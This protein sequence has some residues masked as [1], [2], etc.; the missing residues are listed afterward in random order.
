MAQPPLRFIAVEIYHRFPAPGDRIFRDLP[1]AGANSPSLNCPVAINADAAPNDLKSAV[2]G[3]L[4][5][6]PPTK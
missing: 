4:A 2:Q 6:F 1:G 5:N 3:I